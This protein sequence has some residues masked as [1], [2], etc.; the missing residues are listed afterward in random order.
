M[1]VREGAEAVI[2]QRQKEVG[3]EADGILNN[4]WPGRWLCG[5]RG[6]L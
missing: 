6:A 2:V 5:G 4:G 1:A 3:A